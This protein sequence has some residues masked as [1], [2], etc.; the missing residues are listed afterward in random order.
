MPVFQTTMAASSRFSGD[1]ALGY[2]SKPF[3]K[4]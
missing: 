3:M 2:S 4:R 1:A